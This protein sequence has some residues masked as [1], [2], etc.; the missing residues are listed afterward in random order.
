[1]STV[2]TAREMARRHA[3]PACVGPMLS[4]E[5]DVTLKGEQL[6]VLEELFDEDAT[7]AGLEV[8]APDGSSLGIV[9]RAAVLAYILARPSGT[10]RGGNIG[11]LEGA[12]VSDAPL[13]RCD[14][15]NPPYQRLL[16]AAS[17]QPLKCKECGRKML[18]VPR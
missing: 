3:D 8:F 9:P 10:T 12:P 2:L 4:I 1:M 15:H 6:D 13:F 7:L 14:E 16:W 18:R 17:P 5:A 11:R